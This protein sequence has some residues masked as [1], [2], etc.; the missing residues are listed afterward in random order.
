[1]FSNGMHGGGGQAFTELPSCENSAHPRR[2]FKCVYI[3]IYNTYMYVYICVCIHHGYNCVS[4]SVSPDLVL[5][6][7]S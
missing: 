4:R 1:M 7:L 6:A 3:Y 5:N 2:I